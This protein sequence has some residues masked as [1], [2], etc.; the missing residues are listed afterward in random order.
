[1]KAYKVLMAE[2]ISAS[3]L[4][5]QECLVPEELCMVFPRNREWARGVKFS[6]GMGLRD[7]AASR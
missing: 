5:L 1:M 3:R 4:E 6:V 2:E 7:D